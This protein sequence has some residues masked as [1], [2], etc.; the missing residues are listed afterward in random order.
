MEKNIEHVK[1]GINNS[2]SANNVKSAKNGTENIKI[3]SEKLNDT[4]YE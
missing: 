4:K 2:N 1:I 3:G